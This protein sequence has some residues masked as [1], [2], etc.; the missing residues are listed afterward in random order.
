VARVHGSGHF[1]R[2]HAALVTTIALY[3]HNRFFVCLS[4][5]LSAR[6]AFE[7]QSLPYNDFFYKSSEL[8]RG[9]LARYRWMGEGF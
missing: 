5:C 2:V 9:F 1:R 8:K 7:R 3:Y 4:V 6:H